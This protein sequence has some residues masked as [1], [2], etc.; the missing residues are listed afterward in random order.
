MAYV[1]VAIAVSGMAHMASGLSY[2][3]CGYGP[4]PQA[5]RAADAAPEQQLPALPSAHTVPQYRADRHQ[6]LGKP[7]R[8]QCCEIRSQGADTHAHT[9]V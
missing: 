9:H 6:S 5:V 2:G 8:P 3:P 4:Y 7:A 1:V